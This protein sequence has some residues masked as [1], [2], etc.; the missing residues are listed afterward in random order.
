METNFSTLAD[1][2]R[3]AQAELFELLDQKD[4]YQIFAQK[5]QEISKNIVC[6]A[7]DRRLGFEVIN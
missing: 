3:M 1:I 7:R 6:Q 4:K 2:H 5:C